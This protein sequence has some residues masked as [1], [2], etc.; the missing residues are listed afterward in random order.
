MI[1]YEI[2]MLLNISVACR[3]GTT[4]KVVVGSFTVDTQISGV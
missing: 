4:E 1:R 2:K 3:M